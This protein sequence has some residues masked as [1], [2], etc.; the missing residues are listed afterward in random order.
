[1]N[2]TLISPFNYSNY[3]FLTSNACDIHDNIIQYAENNLNR[4]KYQ[5]EFNNI[6]N[7]ID[8]ALKVEF[9]IFEFALIYTINKN[10][11]FDYINAVYIDKIN[12]IQQNLNPNN[13]INNKTLLP[14]II[15]NIIDPSTI[16]FL[17]PQQLHPEKWK[18]QINKFNY[19]E[20]KEKSIKYSTA[21]KCS[22]CGE[23]K[24][25]ITQSQ[26]RCADEPATTFV[27]C[28]VCHKTFKFS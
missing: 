15:N 14:S 6:F 1:M 22:R 2:N 19:L 28:M 26:T 8:I 27:C 25:K 3:N 17:S 10:L 9:S 18:Y 11:P 12:D 13:K 5:L 21:Y 24:C 16:A 4:V 20:L 23:S 7:N